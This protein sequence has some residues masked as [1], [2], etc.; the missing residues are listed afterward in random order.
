L[1]INDY[2]SISI[3]YDIHKLLLIYLTVQYTLLN[4]TFRH[5]CFGAAFF[6]FL[7]KNTTVIITIMKN[8]SK[9]IVNSTIQSESIA[10]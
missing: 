9:K 5:D 4:L 7:T 6:F 8:N 2:T 3:F 1:Y 10:T